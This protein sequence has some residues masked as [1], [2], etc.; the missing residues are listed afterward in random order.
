M[1]LDRRDDQQQSEQ[2][3]GGQQD[4]AQALAGHAG[5]DAGL[6]VTT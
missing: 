1:V 5:S 2:Q 4:E 3:P 6:A